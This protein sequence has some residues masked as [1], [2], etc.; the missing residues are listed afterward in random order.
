MR[1]IYEHNRKKNKRLKIMNTENHLD[2]LLAKD[3]PYPLPPC[4]GF[5]FVISGASGSGKR[6]CLRR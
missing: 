6:H 2:K 4:S 5:N 1:D 3:I